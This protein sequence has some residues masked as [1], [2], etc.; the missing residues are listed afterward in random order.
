MKLFQSLLVAP[1]AIGLL[2]SISASATELNIKDASRYSQV[3]SIPTFD[4]IYETDWAHKALS[5]IAKSRGCL[6]QIP[7]GNISRIEA[8]TILNKCVTNIA[9]LSDQE[10]RLISEF[11]SELALLNG[12]ADELDSRLSEFEA[13]SFSTT[14][15]ASFSAD[16]AFGAVDGNTSSDKASLIYG[17]QIDL[18]TSFTGEDSLDVSLDAGSG[19]STSPLQELDFNGTNDALTVDG[20]AYTFPLGEKLTVFFGDSMDGSTL[21]NTACVY[22]GQTNT[23]DDC[24]NANSAMAAGYGSAAGASYDFGNGLIASIG[25]EGQGST[26]SNGLLTKEGADVFGGQLSYTSDIYGVSLTYASMETVDSSS[27]VVSNG[28]TTY[29]GFNGYIDPEGDDIIPSISVGY[30]TGD[31]ETSGTSETY[32]WFVGVQWDD[33]ASGT[34]GAALGTTGHTSEDADEYLM[35]EAYY[36]YAINDGVTITPLIYIVDQPAGTDDETGLIVKTSFSF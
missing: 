29:W 9:Q 4:Q 19:T 18:S 22:G 14:T 20:I 36:S 2:S 10:E 25:Y 32:H 7:E 34:L 26:D 5:D 16:F 6:G 12:K 3:A 33:L 1:A 23:L 24:G 11:N 15:A 8:A 13:G 21:Y 28:D 35:Y 17:Y 27:N 31:S 30:E